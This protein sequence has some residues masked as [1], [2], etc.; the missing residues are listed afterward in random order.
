MPLPATRIMLYSATA[1]LSEP[2]RRVEWNRISTGPVM[3]R[4]MC[5]L[6][7][8]GRVPAKLRKRTCLRSG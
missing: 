1:A 3:P 5:S 4:N 2:T 6:N 7:H 8:P